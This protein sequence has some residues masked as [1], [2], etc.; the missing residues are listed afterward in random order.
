MILNRPLYKTAGFLIKVL[1]YFQEKQDVKLRF[2]HT[3]HYQSLF[4]GSAFFEYNLGS[5]LKINLYNDS[6]LSRI[7]YD[8]FEQEELNFMEKALK[9]ED[10]FIDIGANVGLF[11][12]I[13]SH[14][15]IQFLSKSIPSPCF[16]SNR[17][18]SIPPELHP[19]STTTLSLKL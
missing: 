3:K 7:I 18:K 8:G 4:K 5:S 17:W 19:I 6:V 15:L 13:A 10:I 2:Q 16:I 14:A 12:L 11:S 9:K 1:R